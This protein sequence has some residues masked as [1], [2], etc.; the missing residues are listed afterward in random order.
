MNRLRLW[1]YMLLLLGVGAADLYVVSR[2][3][4]ARELEEADGRLRAAAAQ[5]EVRSRLL[6]RQVGNVAEAASRDPSLA[7]ALS[8]KAPPEKPGR[9]PRPRPPPLPAPSAAQVHAAGEAAVRQAERLTGVELPRGSAVGMTR[10]ETLAFRSGGKPVGSDKDRAACAWLAAARVGSARQGYVRLEGTVYFAAA[11][12]APGGA[13]LAVAQPL[14]GGW[15]AGVKTAGPDVTLAVESKQPLTTLPPG[16]AR[17]L[18]AVQMTPG[19]PV[20]VGELGRVEAA[21]G[22]PLPALPILFASAPAYRA[23]A[24]AL[25]ALPG[26]AVILS[27]AMRPRLAALAALQQATLLAGAFLLAV[28][29][30]LGLFMSSGRRAA[31][32]P[33]DLVTAADR[34]TRG[35]FEARVPMM[36][37]AL[38]TVAEALNRA[39]E[40]AQAAAAGAAPPASTSEVLSALDLPAARTEESGETTAREFA[41]PSRSPARPAAAPAS[42]SDTS[43]LDGSELFGAPRAQAAGPRAVPPAPPIPAARPAPPAAAA[44]GDDTHFREVFDEFLRVR[45]ECGEAVEGLTYDRFL[46]KL[47]KNRDSLV[48]KYACRT[49]RFQVYVKDGKAAL[50]AT[51]VR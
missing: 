1:L 4:A 42:P 50:K 30:A 24:V 17:R 9:R 27:E 14:E 39:A 45:R 22:L 13:A 34:I 2:Q 10:D 8:P 32:L 44:V 26:A 31:Q 47:R 12:P 36:A 15:L 11:V 6:A 23:Q 38:G 20:D 35:D 21:G 48:Q 16:E 25:E 18:L 46:A 43:R 29:L 33:K 28:G 40:A 51:P 5:L 37:G 19:R 41:A 49:V 7:E 3:L